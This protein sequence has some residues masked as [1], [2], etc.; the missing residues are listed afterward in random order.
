MINNMHLKFNNSEV[1]NGR[2]SFSSPIPLYMPHVEEVQP[3]KQKRNYNILTYFMKPEEFNNDPY[4]PGWIKGAVHTA[5]RIGTVAVIG[6]FL[7]WLS[8]NLLTRD[9]ER[10][11][12]FLAM[13]NQTN[14][15]LQELT[16]AVHELKVTVEQIK[17]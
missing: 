16:V 2:M 9:D 17:R 11:T 15:T 14:I 13:C 5:E 1:N 8:L 10:N 3:K 7:G 4:I 12:R 6:L